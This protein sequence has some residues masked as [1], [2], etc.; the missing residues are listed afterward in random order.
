MRGVIRVEKLMVV[1]GSNLLFQMFY[2]MP[3]R[4]VDGQGKAIQGTLGFVGALLKIIRMVQPT[5]IVVLFDGESENP[6]SELDPDY[7]GNREDYSQM[8]E[9][10][11][12]FSQLPDICAALDYMGI[13]RCETTVCEVD[14]W[15]A[16][17][18]QTYGDSTEIVIVSQDSDFFQLIRDRVCVL[19]YRGENSVLCNTKYIQDK[20]GIEPTQYA[21]YKSLTGDTSDNIRGVDK[22]GPKTAAA[23]MR[24]FGDLDTLLEQ[25]DSIQ[26]PSVRCSVLESIERIRKNF[27]LIHLSGEQPLP[28]TLEELAYCYDGITTTEVLK[29]IGLRDA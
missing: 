17:Y 10:E 14:D 26:K 2:G 8:P 4:I 9:E 19:R 6:R 15:I 21:A 24:Q 20:L 5:H 3:A 12:P 25:A 1:D 7:K 13:H 22:V 28:F 16:G 27:A 18:A 11:T 29:A 23:L